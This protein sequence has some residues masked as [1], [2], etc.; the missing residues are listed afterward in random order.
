MNE[1]QEWQGSSLKEDVGAGDMV[2]P[3]DPKDETQTLCGRP[4]VFSH[5]Q[6][7]EPRSRLHIIEQI[8]RE[9]GRYGF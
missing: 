4:P 3:A 1:V 2:V 9:I 7:A 5:L 8:G 6:T